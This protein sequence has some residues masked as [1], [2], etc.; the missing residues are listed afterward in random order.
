MLWRDWNKE[1]FENLFFFLCYLLKSNYFLVHFPIG[2]WHYCP[3][4]VRPSVRPS[5]C[6]LTP[7]PVFSFS[8]IFKIFFDRYFS[9]IFL[10]IIFS[11]I[12]W[13]LFFKYF[14]IVIFKKNFFNTNLI[15]DKKFIHHLQG[16]VDKFF[17][18][19]SFVLVFFTLVVC[20][21]CAVVQENT[22]PSR[23]PWTYH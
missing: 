12:F 4:N 10:T 2:K 13:P 8:V 1:G 15:H 9:N 14:L 18:S 7:P 23:S 6:R 3:P 11:N 5:V 19:V 21:H 20:A 16:L 17:A 22:L